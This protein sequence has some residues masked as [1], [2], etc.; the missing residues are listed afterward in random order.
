MKKRIKHISYRKFVKCIDKLHT[1]IAAFLTL[2][3]M[4]IDYV[5]PVLR[6]GA[7]PAT[8]LAQRLVSVKFAPVQVKWV[9]DGKAVKTDTLEE[10]NE[11]VL[12][13]NSL[14][15]I[16]H[17]SPT[18]LVVDATYGSGKSIASTIKEIYQTIPDAK[19]ILAIVAKNARQ[20]LPANTLQNFY[21]FEFNW[22]KTA[23]EK[24]I[25]CYPWE[26]P[27]FELNHPDDLKENIFF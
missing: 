27:E 17:P 22:K 9:S 7:I 14:K 8:Y 16:E 6:S 24:T 19:I 21:A 1:E 23:K 3:K 5:V 10:E 12:L 26:I 25:I 11:P 18:L 4:R 2:K 15:L 13:L 20:P